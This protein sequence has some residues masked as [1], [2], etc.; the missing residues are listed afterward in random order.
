MAEIAFFPV[1]LVAF[2]GNFDG[3]SV[4]VC[5]LPKA[6]CLENEQQVQSRTGVGRNTSGT[7]VLLDGGGEDLLEQKAESILRL[8]VDR[9]TSG[10]L[11][12]E[13]SEKAVFFE[14]EFQH[15]AKRGLSFLTTQVQQLRALR[16]ARFVSLANWG[17][18]RSVV[19]SLS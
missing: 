12:G 4:G 13:F 15:S 11:H 7:P 3:A 5:V 14:H 6:V 16:A 10:T 9:N 17:Y 8:G 18:Y 1:K 19:V 2:P